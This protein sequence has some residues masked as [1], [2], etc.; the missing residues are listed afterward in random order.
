MPYTDLLNGTWMS[1]RSGLHSSANQSPYQGWSS[2]LGQNFNIDEYVPFFERSYNM[3]SASG[4]ALS[5]RFL[6]FMDMTHRER[7]YQRVTME[8]LNFSGGISFRR[9]RLLS[10]STEKSFRFRLFT[11][12]IRAPVSRAILTSVSS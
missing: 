8:A 2:A 7:A 11:P 6:R 5:L 12:M 1:T 10:G 4:K 3:S 9:R